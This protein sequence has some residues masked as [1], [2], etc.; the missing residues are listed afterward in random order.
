MRPCNQCGDPIENRRLL[1]ESCE[2]H[3]P[4]VSSE[5]FATKDANDQHSFQTSNSDF[6]MADRISFALEVALGTFICAIPVAIVSGIALMF[7]LSPVQAFTIATI[8]GL[9]AGFGWT[10]LEQFFTAGSG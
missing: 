4:S 2:T 6:T 7:V 1:C 9:V 5:K 3:D 10:L 8:V